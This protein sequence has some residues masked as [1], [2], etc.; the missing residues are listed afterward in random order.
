MNEILTALGYDPQ[1]ITETHRLEFSELLKMLNTG[2]CHFDEKIAL[3]EKYRDVIPDLMI[4]NLNS[5]RGSELKTG[6]PYTLD[7]ETRK[8]YGSSFAWYNTVVADR[9]EVGPKGELNVTPRTDMLLYCYLG[10]KGSEPTIVSIKEVVDYAVTFGPP[11]GR[12]GDGEYGLR[13]FH[14][15]KECKTAKYATEDTC[16]MVTLRPLDKTL[17]LCSQDRIINLVKVGD[18][19]TAVTYVKDDT[20]AYIPYQ[21]VPVTQELQDAYITLTTKCCDSEVAVDSLYK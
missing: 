8:Q 5:K 6:I 7:L 20:G 18:T 2:E 1:D 21:E 16:S 13:L 12:L 15:L 4:A 10:T 19:I 17:T 14:T 9:R 11:T 3:I